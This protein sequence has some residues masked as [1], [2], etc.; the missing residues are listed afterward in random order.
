MAHDI[1][2]AEAFQLV[3]CDASSSAKHNSK[4]SKNCRS[5]NR[6]E[7]SNKN[8]FP[9]SS[10]RKSKEIPVCLYAAHQSRGLIHYL[11]DCRECP[12]EELKTLYK[13][14]YENKTPDPLN[15][16]EDSLRGN[17]TRKGTQ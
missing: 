15:L 16:I 9:T 5:G 17:K 12:D 1:K 11:Q 8:T 13:Q 14:H 10:M 2:L 7:P 6:P 4:L 3:D